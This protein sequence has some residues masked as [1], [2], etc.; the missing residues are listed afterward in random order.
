MQ[1]G[2]AVNRRTIP[3][4]DELDAI[5]DEKL[6]ALVRE[7]EDASWSAEDIALTLEEVLQRKWLKQVDAL[8]RARAAVPD[9]F[10]SDGNEG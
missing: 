5:V 10:V 7:L 6:T 3:L 4:V 9:D 8:R 1:K 2:L